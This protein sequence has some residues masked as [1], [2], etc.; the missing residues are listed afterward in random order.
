M[1]DL[2]VT[3][4]GNA[5]SGDDPEQHPEGGDLFC[6]KGLGVKGVERGRYRG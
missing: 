2:Y 3:T 4:A 1:N 5:C 6:I